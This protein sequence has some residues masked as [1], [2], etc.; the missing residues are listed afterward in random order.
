MKVAQARADADEAAAGRQLMTRRTR[1]VMRL[2]GARKVLAG[3]AAP[4]APPGAVSISGATGSASFP[5]GYVPGGGG[6]GF[7]G[8]FGGGGFRLL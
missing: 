6:G 3:L 5:L 2:F 4:G 8:G 1:R 7:G